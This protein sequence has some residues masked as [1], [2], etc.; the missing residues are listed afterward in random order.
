M[1]YYPTLRKGIYKSLQWAAIEDLRIHRIH[2]FIIREEMAK[3]S[4]YKIVAWFLLF[5]NRSSYADGHVHLAF[6]HRP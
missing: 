3:S 1:T 5:N 2:L 6:C 4:K